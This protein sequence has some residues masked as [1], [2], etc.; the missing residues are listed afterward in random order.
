MKVSWKWLQNYVDLE[1]LTPKEVAE[2]MTLVSLEEEGIV[3]AGAMWD[4]VIV[5]RIQDV[6]K[7]PDA[8]KLHIVT[9]DIGDGATET[10]VCGGTNIEIGM[11]PQNVPLA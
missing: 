1:G 2:R 11:E 3:D 9:V 7:H 6:Q 8:D 4:G 10:I 5:A